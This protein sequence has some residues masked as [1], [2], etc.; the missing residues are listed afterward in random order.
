[1]SPRKRS[2]RAR[3]RSSTAR[4][5]TDLLATRIGLPEERE[6]ISPALDHIASRSTSAKGASWPSKMRS[7]VEWSMAGSL[8]ANG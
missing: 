3:M 7:S 8:T 5:R 4:A 6:S 2:S 1:M